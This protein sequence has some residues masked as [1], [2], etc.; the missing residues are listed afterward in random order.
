MLV[1]VN[2]KKFPLIKRR[3]YDKGRRKEDDMMYN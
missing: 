3:F 1:A 2:P